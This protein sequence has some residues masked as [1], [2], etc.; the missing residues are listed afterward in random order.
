MQRHAPPKHRR[1]SLRLPQLQQRAVKGF[2]WRDACVAAGCDSFWTCLG[3]IL[4]PKLSG[5][6]ALPWIVVIVLAVIAAVMFR[7][8]MVEVQ[9]PDGERIGTMDSWT[10]RV[11]LA[12]V[13]GP[14]PETISLNDLDF[15]TAEPI[16]E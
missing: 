6:K 2:A 15:T 16:P 12:P 11:E 10:G 13:A 14:T 3:A 5:M 7:F 8:Q 4:M 1:S 9:T